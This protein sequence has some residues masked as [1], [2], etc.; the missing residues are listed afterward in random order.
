[1]HV[2]E[3]ARPRARVCPDRRGGAL[4]ARLPAGAVRE[5]S[6]VQLH[7]S[8][9]VPAARGAAAPCVQRRGPALRDARVLLAAR[10]AH[11]ARERE[12][13]RRRL[14]ARA[15]QPVHLAERAVRSAVQHLVERQG[16]AADDGLGAGGQYCPAVT[17]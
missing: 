7:R 1:M 17:R 9:A 6:Q 15:E 3:S 10:R 2:Q 8:P 11:T 5:E 16:G 13:S 14:R 4:G 12:Q